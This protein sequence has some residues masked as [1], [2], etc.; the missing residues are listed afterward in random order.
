MQ[1]GFH[2]GFLSGGG[3]ANVT[4][5]ELGGGAKSVAGFSFIR[6]Q[7]YSAC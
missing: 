4:F 2:L 7:N 6:G 1:P 5:A 3:G